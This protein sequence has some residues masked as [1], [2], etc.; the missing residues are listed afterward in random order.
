MNETG[1]RGVCFIAG[2]AVGWIQILVAVEIVRWL[3]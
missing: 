3:A 2:M 1:M